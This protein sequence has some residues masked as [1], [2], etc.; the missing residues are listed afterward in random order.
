M[1]S[2]ADDE[3][4]SLSSPRTRAFYS[5][6]RVDILSPK[7]FA[8]L[9]CSVSTRRKNHYEHIS[10]PGVEGEPV[11]D[12]RECFG[13]GILNDSWLTNHLEA[14]RS[15]SGIENVCEYKQKI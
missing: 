11:K 14:S 15:L 4:M 7:Y 5:P 1:N 6:L 2:D 8:S 12:D 3:P 13:D 10:Q 9:T